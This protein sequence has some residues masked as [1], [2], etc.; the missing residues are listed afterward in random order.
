MRWQLVLQTVQA[1]ATAGAIAKI[2]I[3]TTH[4]NTRWDYL[5][6]F[7]AIFTSQ[8]ILLYLTRPKSPTELVDYSEPY[9]NFFSEWYTGEGEHQI[10]CDDL[11]W[12]DD[13]RMAGVVHVIRRHPTR[14]EVYTREPSGPVYIDLR[15]AG[16][17]VYAVPANATTASTLS[18]LH[19]QGTYKMIIRSKESG[20]SGSK[21]YIQETQSPE[22]IALAIDL[23]RT[24]K[25]ANAP[26]PPWSH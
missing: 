1:V 14:F 24:I 20:R 23:L 13:H 4:G 11:N 12:L 8:I 9:V 26:T 10:Y 5:A 17:P 2:G 6:L 15:A 21:I 18:L 22:T 25:D 19:Y 16:V 3:D 7:A